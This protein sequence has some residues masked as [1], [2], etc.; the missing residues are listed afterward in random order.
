MDIA[1]LNTQT[2]NFYTIGKICFDQIY[3]ATIE[4]HTTDQEKYETYLIVINNIIELNIQ[5]PNPDNETINGSLVRKISIDEYL[6]TEKIYD[7][8][9]K[10][11]LH[12]RHRYYKIHIDFGQT[13]IFI[14]K[15]VNLH[16]IEY[17]P[18]LYP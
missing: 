6:H 7:H 17:H 1:Q 11:T 4:L 12:K 9:S 10:I 8:R 13:M 14:A 3:D 18:T 16:P 15:F 5:N 2:T